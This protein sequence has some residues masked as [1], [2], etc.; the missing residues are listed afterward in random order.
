MVTLRTCKQVSKTAV[1]DCKLQPMNRSIVPLPA[2]VEGLV[3]YSSV[4]LRISVRVSVAPL[5]SSPK[6]GPAPA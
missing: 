2:F 1:S 3:D 6:T 5:S 4:P